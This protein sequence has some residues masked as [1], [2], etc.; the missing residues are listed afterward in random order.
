MLGSICGPVIRQRHDKTRVAAGATVKPVP[1]ANVLI[2][3]VQKLCRVRLGKFYLKTMPRRRYPVQVVL[4][5]LQ[6]SEY[7]HTFF[8]KRDEETGESK[9]LS[10][11]QVPN[12]N[13]V[14]SNQP[15]SDLFS[16]GC[17]ETAV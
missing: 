2:N 15:I 14:V 16:E 1:K 11:T 17:M 9:I 5:W 7:E 8:C 10:I 12:F 3:S 13:Q 4:A 6:E